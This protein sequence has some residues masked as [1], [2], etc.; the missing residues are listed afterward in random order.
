M[1]NIRIPLL[2]LY[3]YDNSIFDGLSLPDGIDKELLIDR[4][5]IRGGEYESVY[6]SVPFLKSAI[7]NWSATHRHLID[8][9]LEVYNKDFEPLENYDRI[10]EWTDDGNNIANSTD[11]TKGT[12]TTRGTGTTNGSDQAQAHGNVTGTNTV[13]AYNTNNLVNDNGTSQ[14]NT[15]NT[16]SSTQT[17]STTQ[18]N[19]TTQSDKTTQSNDVTHSKHSG[20][21]HGNIGV[22]TSMQMY[23]SFWNLMR[24]YGDIYNAI[25]TL[26]LQDFVV[27]IL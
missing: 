6:T 1:D 11:T 18:S 4:I 19:T 22:T 23:E 13:S 7:S 9:W 26:F 20:R 2:T 15:T 8:K 21:V 10:E 17:N 12:D 25:A 3:N 27:P 16:S 14:G 5:M 24:E